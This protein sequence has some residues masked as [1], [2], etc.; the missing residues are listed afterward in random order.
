MRGV[1]QCTNR[2]IPVYKPAD[3]S[4]RVPT[5]G[6]DSQIGEALPVQ[7]IG[8]PADVSLGVLRWDADPVRVRTYASICSMIGAVAWSAV[9][10]SRDVTTPALTRS[11]S[12]SR[13]AR[14][15]QAALSSRHWVLTVRTMPPESRNFA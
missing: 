11:A 12:R 13:R 1:F 8:E 3:F 2:P 14:T 5:L 7:V 4:V 15:C 6:T 10:S 9:A